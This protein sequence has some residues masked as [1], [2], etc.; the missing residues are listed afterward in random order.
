MWWFT[1]T[2][3]ILPLHLFYTVCVIAI[4]NLSSLTEWIVLVQIVVFTLTILF[5]L[6]MLEQHTRVYVVHDDRLEIKYFIGLSN[7]TYDFNDLKFARDS[8]PLKTALLELPNGRQLTLVKTL[9]TNYDEIVMTLRKRI[10]NE[11]LKFKFVNRLTVFVV[12]AI[13][14][15]LFLTTFQPGKS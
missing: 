13:L 5:L 15:L 10:Q 6:I 4:D 11:K 12:V 9:Y 3:T 2:L 1:L 14:I 8:W 7:R